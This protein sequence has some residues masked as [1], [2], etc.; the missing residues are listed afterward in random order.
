MRAGLSYGNAF[1]SGFTISPG[2]FLAHD[3][4]GYSSDG[5]FLENRTVIGLGV[6]ADYLKKYTINLG[7]TKY[8]DRAKFDPYRDRD[9]YSVSVSTTF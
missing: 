7:Y 6:Q 2:V 3:V 8:G 5:Q 4:K 9:Y 1:G